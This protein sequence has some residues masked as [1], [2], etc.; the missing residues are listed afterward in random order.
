MRLLLFRSGKARKRFV[1]APPLILSEICLKSRICFHCCCGISRTAIFVFLSHFP[2]YLFS[3]AFSGPPCTRSASSTPSIGT[4]LG[5]RESLARLPARNLVSHTSS[6][7]TCE[8]SNL[9][10][11]NHGL[12]RPL[13]RLVA[14]L[15]LISVGIAYPARFLT[16]KHGFQPSAIAQVG[17]IRRHTRGYNMRRTWRVRHERLSRGH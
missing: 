11:T 5:P 7:F 6:S 16:L 2:C 9:A 13:G 10:F 12:H 15:P 3:P 17:S 14:D 1:E 8:T 4:S